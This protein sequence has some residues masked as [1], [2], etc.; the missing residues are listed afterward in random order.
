MAE[1]M[2]IRERTSVLLTGLNMGMYEREESLRLAF[3]SAIAGESIFF[4]G[5]PGVAKSLI[6]R[7]LKFAFNDSK[8]FEYLMNRFST[9]DE[10]FG[11]VSI[12][13]LK[14]EDKYV[15]LT[16]NYLPGSNIVFLDEI[17]KAGPSIQNALLTILN[18]K[19]YRNGDQ[20]V[21]V[22]LR[23]IIS[24]S[25]ELPAEGQ[26]LEALWDR[27]LVRCFVSGITDKGN[28]NQMITGV[29]NLYVDNI[30]EDYKL[31]DADINHYE[32]G[33]AAVE[34]PIEVLDLIH[35]IRLSLQEENKKMENEHF[36]VSD[37]RWKKIVHLLK[38]SAYLNG[39][40]KVDLM[41]CFLISNCIWQRPEEIGVVK[42]IVAESIRRNTYSIN[43][44]LKPLD[45]E[46][47]AFSKDVLDE[48]QEK[49]KVKKT[50]PQIFDSSYYGVKIP[51]SKSKSDKPDQFIKISD[52]NTLTKTDKQVYLYEAK[53]SSY[54]QTSRVNVRMEDKEY[55]IHV[56]WNDYNYSDHSETCT[57]IMTTVEDVE[58]IH[59]EPHSVLIDHWDKHAGLLTHMV[60]EQKKELE[61][62]ILTDLGMIR[63]NIFVDASNAEIVEDKVKSLRKTLEGMNLSIE[64]TIHLYS[65]N[66]EGKT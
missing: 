49:R 33:I 39:R 45:N 14:D 15:R 56:Y 9:P 8:S 16:E 11:P 57:I 22:R 40:P 34:V 52:Y 50:F 58:I 31:N 29:G 60:D 13:K 24:A 64:K 48:T 21:E 55:Q 51:S 17:W 4:L 53:G 12:K 66:Q 5:P 63:N 35:A 7:R 23:G 32:D 30:P 42:Q 20:E 36:Y 10:I 26:G 3:L 28:F 2:N 18:E 61:R 44:N 43:L 1:K 37:R 46:I 19:V 59:K 41:D 27:F 6:A 62:Y 47:A 38:A 25:N 54:S 65:N